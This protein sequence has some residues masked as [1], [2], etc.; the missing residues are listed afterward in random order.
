[1]PKEEYP[2]GVIVA[3]FVGKAQNLWPGLP[4]SAIAK[5]PVTGPLLLLENGLAGDQQADQS[6]HG[7][8]EKAVHHYPAEH[9]DFWKKELPEHADKFT[10]GCFGENVTTSGLDESNICLGDIVQMGTAMLQVLQGRQPCWKLEKHLGINSIAQKFRQT[11]KTGW[12]YRVLKNGVINIGDPVFVRERLHPEWSI[13]KL[14]KAFFADSLNSGVCL[15]LS[16]KP[17]LSK[18]WRKAFL[19]KLEPVGQSKERR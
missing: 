3:L 4:P 11:A 18:A 2:T 7:G 6:V 8:P 13:E 15:E 12:Y 1:M 17:A 9:L 5:R 10:C 14:T 16:E 19:K